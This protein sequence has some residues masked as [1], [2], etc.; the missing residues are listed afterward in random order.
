MSHEIVDERTLQS[1]KFKIIINSTIIG[2]LQFERYKVQN[3]YNVQKIKHTHNVTV[4]GN[5]LMMILIYNSS[6]KL[7]F[8][9]YKIP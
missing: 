9:L 1:T 6:A 5:G 3:F 4:E 7:H 2:K 8:E